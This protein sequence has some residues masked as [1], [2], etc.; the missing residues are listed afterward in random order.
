M[1]AGRACTGR[2]WWEGASRPSTVGPRGSALGHPRSPL[3]LGS[4][5]TSPRARLAPPAWGAPPSDGAGG[6]AVLTPLVNSPDLGWGVLVRNHPATHSSAT[7]ASQGPASRAHRRGLRSRTRGC[8]CPASPHQTAQDLAGCAPPSCCLIFSST[9]SARLYLTRPTRP[10]N[11]LHRN[12][13]APALPVGRPP[14]RQIGKPLLE[15]PGSHRELDWE[16]A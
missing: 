5:A 9:P 10:S 13:N 7:R 6:S 15:N 8:G 12:L 1:L 2:G 11:S 14:P 3:P 16:K 4:A